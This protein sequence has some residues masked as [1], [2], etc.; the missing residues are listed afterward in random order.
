MRKLCAGVMCFGFIGLANALPTIAMPDL[1]MNQSATVP[2]PLKNFSENNVM[3]LPITIKQNMPQFS[4]DIRGGL[5]NSGRFKVINIKNVKINNAKTLNDMLN[6][7]SALNTTQVFNVANQL[8]NAN[9]YPTAMLKPVESGN[10]V[11]SIVSSNNINA[12]NAEYYLLGT[13]NDVSQNEDSYPIKDTTNMTKQYFVAVSGDFKLVRAKDNVI[14]A[15]FSSTG[16]AHDVK[17]VA[18]NA[19]QNIKWHHNTGALVSEAAK[20]LAANVVTQVIRQFAMT[21]KQDELNTAKPDV[22]TDVKTYN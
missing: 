12:D 11:E 1:I 6:Q 4:A 5:I 3:A 22:V 20:N 2:V 15:S 7:L 16:E 14:V 10:H 18:I 19:N 9:T 21:T 8:G 17:L 13:I